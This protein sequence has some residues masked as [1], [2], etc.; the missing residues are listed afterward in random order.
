MFNSRASLNTQMSSHLYMKYDCAYMTVIRLKKEA[1]DRNYTNIIHKFRYSLFLLDRPWLSPWIKL[2]SNELDRSSFFSSFIVALCRVRNKIMYA[3]WWRTVSA[4]PRVLFLYLFPSL[5]RNSGNKHRNN[6][7]VSAETVG[8][9][10]TYIILYILQQYIYIYTYITY[11][12]RD[13]RA[14]LFLPYHSNASLFRNV[15]YTTG[16]ICAP[17]FHAATHIQQQSAIML[18]TSCILFIH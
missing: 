15:I 4:L 10:R 6:P 5:L 18:T 14:N 17:L 8:H 12:S 3:F 13:R 11:G 9:S 1:R 7:F 16:C 2:I